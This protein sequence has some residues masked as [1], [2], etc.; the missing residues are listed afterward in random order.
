MEGVIFDL[1]RF[2]VHDGPGIRSTVFFQGCSCRCSWC[3]NPESRDTTPQLEYY[4]SRCIGCG[5]CLPVCLSGALQKNTEGL[6]L[7]RN[8]CI[9]CGACAREC[10][11]AAL[12]I[13]GTKVTVPQLMPRLMADAPY[14]ETSGGGVTLSGGEPLLQQEFA[15]ELLQACKSKGLHTVL[16]TA[17]NYP[18]AALEPLLPFL[19]M[20][21]YDLKA[22]DPAIYQHHIRGDRTLILDNL[23]KLDRLYQGE[24]VVR[25]PCISPINDS[26]AEITAIA[27]YASTLDHLLYYQLIPYHPLAQS[28]YDALRV[29]FASHLATPTREA[30]ATLE[31]AARHYLRVI[32]YH[33]KEE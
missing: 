9:S 12:V 33:H 14:Y 7:N 4:P 15:L 28:K 3:H 23:Q 25:T 16:Q 11:A 5:A 2:T 8:Y 32:S 19:D 29:E 10:F 26:V 18:W 17:G 1:Q 20:I 13:K 21:M 31:E 27:Q 22:W 24:I 6:T 30:L